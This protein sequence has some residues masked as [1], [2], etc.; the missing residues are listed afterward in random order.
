MSVLVI[1]VRGFHL[2]YLGAYGNAWLPTPHLD[3]LAAESIVFDHHFAD[4]PSPSGA[5][6][7]WRL[8]ELLDA[9]RQRGITTS[10][11]TDRPG[12]LTTG[13]GH[14]TESRTPLAKL[15]KKPPPFLWLDVGALLPPWNVPEDRLAEL[16]DVEDE[17]LEPLLDPAI[18]LID[19]DDDTQ[20]LRLQR[21]YGAAVCCF[22]EALGD[23]LD[24]VAD[25]VTIVLTSDHGLPLGEHGAVGLCRPWLHEELVH[26]P[27]M[28]RLPDGAA[29]DR[30]ITSFTQASDLPATWLELLGLPGN[31]PS[32][33]S[34]WKGERDHLHEHACSTLE[35]GEATEW[36]IRTPRWACLVPLRPWPG[37]PPRGP[38][39]YVKPDDRW[40]VNDVRQHHL[41]LAEELERQIED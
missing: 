27:L 17:A 40:E 18:G 10:L 20:F 24:R 28:I 30:R 15:G 32:F 9:C 2:G 6:Q 36:A 7:S 12:S 5:E 23:L 41:E 1:M 19:R 3:R 4:V 25:N 33:S 39:L 8:P 38:Q 37:D 13:W 29:A 35:L 16:F 21:S 34:L 11:V 14:V 31:G 26:I 22:D